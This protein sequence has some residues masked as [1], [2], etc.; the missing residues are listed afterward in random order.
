[1]K[2]K[3]VKVY[4]VSNGTETVVSEKYYEKYKEGLE[5]IKELPK[6]PT[7]SRKPKA[8]KE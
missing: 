6:K 3:L 5:L 8:T 2:D 1:M 7:R 4:V